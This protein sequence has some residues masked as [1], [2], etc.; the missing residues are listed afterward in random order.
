MIMMTKAE[1]ERRERLCL[2]KPSAGRFFGQSPD[3][4][5]NADSDDLPLR[6]PRNAGFVAWSLVLWIVLLTLVSG[7]RTFMG[8]VRL[9]GVGW[10]SRRFDVDMRSWERK[11]KSVD[12]VVGDETAKAISVRDHFLTAQAFFV[13]DVNEKMGE[14]RNADLRSSSIQGYPAFGNVMASSPDGEFRLNP[15]WLWFVRRFGQ[16]DSSIGQRNYGVGVRYKGGRSSRVFNAIF[17]P[18]TASN[19][20]VAEC[21]RVYLY[22]QNLDID[23]R[24]FGKSKGFFSDATLP[25]DGPPLEQSKARINNADDQQALLNAQG[26]EPGFVLGALLLSGSFLLMGYGVKRLDD[27]R[28]QGGLIVLVGGLGAYSGGCLM[29]FGTWY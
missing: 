14:F 26:S 13:D 17:Y 23:I 11:M 15:V 18:Q 6:R 7:S 24:S 21:P 20:R 5:G 28:I 1:A 12:I 22:F 27:C 10:D 16:R 25:I 29:F 4:M 8:G 3:F 2:H 9:C 19:Y